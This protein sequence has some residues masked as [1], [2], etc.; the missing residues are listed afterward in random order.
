MSFSEIVPYSGLW[1]QQG[2]GHGLPDP[3]VFSLQVTRSGEE[4]SAELN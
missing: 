2:S 3:K 4:V 1:T